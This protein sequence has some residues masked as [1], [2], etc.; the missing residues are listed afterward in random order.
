[1][2]GWHHGSEPTPS[3]GDTRDVGSV[4]G[5]GR[6]PRVGKWQPTPVTCLENSIDRGAWQGI[7]HGGLRES[8]T[9]EHTA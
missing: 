4:L 8:D 7:V 2:T 5:S 3:A 6:S 9:A 1:M